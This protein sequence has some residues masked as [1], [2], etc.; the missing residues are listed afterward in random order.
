MTRRSRLVPASS[1]LVAIAAA[2]I[3]A[4]GEQSLKPWIE[5]PVRYIARKEEARDFRK[6]ATEEDRAYFI[7]RF[8]ARRDPTPETI[9]NERRQMFWERVK[10]AND[11][12]LDSTKPGWKTDRGKIFILYGPPSETFEDVNLRTRSG[13]NAG[14]GLIRWIYDGRPGGRKDLAPTVVVPF[15]RDN[16]GEYRLSYDPKLASIFFDPLAIRE[17]RDDELERFY[18]LFGRSRSQLSIMLDLG[19]MQEVPP[20]EQV[21]LE[22]VE[23]IEAY[24]TVPVVTQLDPFAH[25]GRDGATMSITIDLSESSG[26]HKPAIIARFVPLD[27]TKQTRILGEDSFLVDGA[28]D[29]LRAQGRITLDPGR[30]AFTVLVADPVAVRTGLH[31]STVDVPGQVPRMRFSALVWADVLESL[32]YRSLVS[33]D[34]PFIVGPFRVVPRLDAIFH[35]GESVKLFYEVY[36]AELP[37]S[38]RYQLEGRD[39]DGSWIELGRPLSIEQNAISVGWEQ[40]TGPDWPVGEYRVL[41]EVRDVEERMIST[42]QPFILQLPEVAS[43]GGSGS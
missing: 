41:I 34:E 13:P 33:Y 37:L 6:L 28:A 43:S 18:D 12:F 10:Q 5:G 32:P 39:T 14:T 4:M 7:E 25:P 26:G 35:P 9:T 22:R 3:P 1:L 19:R 21:L 16:S 8:W 36:G 27:A 42:T 15:V 29:R 23:T 20:H 2:A 11:Q 30:Y 24:R 40:P 38:I 31:R 17:R